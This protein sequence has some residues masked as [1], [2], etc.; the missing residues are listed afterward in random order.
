[1]SLQEGREQIPDL[2]LPH[3]NS[4]HS[5]DAIADIFIS[6]ETDSAEGTTVACKNE[7]L[8]KLGDPGTIRARAERRLSDPLVQANKRLVAIYKSIVQQQK[9]NVE[10]AEQE[11]E[12]SELSG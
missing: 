4:D 12:W 1:M 8:S 9:I 5:I 2:L 11:Q 3:I 6:N 7:Y 10:N